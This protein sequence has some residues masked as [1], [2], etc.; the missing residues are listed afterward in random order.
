VC[1][2]VC[3]YACA[4]V[5]AGVCMCVHARVCACVRATMLILCNHCI[6]TNIVY[7]VVLI[8]V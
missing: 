2:C 4:C 6:Y 7:I 3:R 1:V 8:D 5:C